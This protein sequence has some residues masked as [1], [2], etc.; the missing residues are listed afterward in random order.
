MARVVA[1]YGGLYASHIRDEESLLLEAVDEAITIGSA[2]GS[3]TI[4]N[5]S[6]DNVLT[7]DITLISAANLVTTADSLEFSGVIDDAAG[8]RTPAMPA[9]LRSRVA[10]LALPG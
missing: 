2:G 8:M 10:R 5:I 3:A 6:G 7:G 1:R 9:V 4:E